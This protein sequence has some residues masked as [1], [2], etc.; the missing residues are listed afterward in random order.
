M[1][2]LL[3]CFGEELVN[4]HTIFDVPSPP[5]L[6]HYT[7]L[8]WF[9]KIMQS[10]QVFMTDVYATNDYLECRIVRH[11]ISR[12]QKEFGE[13]ADGFFRKFW[14]MYCIKRA[15]IASFSEDGDILRSLC[16]TDLAGVPPRC[17]RLGGGGACRVC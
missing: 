15:Y 12:L 8:D 9:V 13:G 1:P 17:E 7:S 6:Y 4:Y 5:K 2:N 16:E 11:W 10:R 14:A 3:E